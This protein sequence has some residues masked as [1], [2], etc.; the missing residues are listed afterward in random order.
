MK[1]IQNNSKEVLEVYGIYQVSNCIYY[2]VS[3]A[4]YAGIHAV[5]DSDVMV[6]DKNI[7]GDYF[8]E[9][10]PGEGFRILSKIIE[11]EKFLEDLLEYDS[12]AFE[13]FD[14]LRTLSE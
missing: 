3:P 2:L 12:E 9:W 7:S 10:R 1:I 11:D 4:G 13:K 5:K 8:F 14:R 6:V